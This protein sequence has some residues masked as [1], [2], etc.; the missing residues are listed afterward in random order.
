MPAFHIF[1]D[2]TLIEIAQR[3][4]Q[5]PEQFLG[6]HGVGELKLAN[7]GQ[8][9]LE[10]IRDHPADAPAPASSNLEV[11]RLPSARMNQIALLFEQ[12]QTVEQIAAD[13]K[14]KSETVI[15]H[16]QRF[17]S[18]GGTLDPSKVLSESK[19][20]ISE[21]ARVFEAFQRIGPERLGE[22]YHALA[23]AVPYQELHML[24]LYWFCTVPRPD[25]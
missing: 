1:S 11:K 13:Y 23:G 25:T 12:G 24:R 20:E 8:Q 18:S 19:L 2:R 3:Q 22:V 15:R 21:Q 16:L 10:V 4:P 9:F 7:Y 14:I 17:Q 6:V 5:T